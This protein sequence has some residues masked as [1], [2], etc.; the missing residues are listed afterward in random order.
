MRG[1]MFH[2]DRIMGRVVCGNLESRDGGEIGEHALFLT[3][4]Q[5]FFAKANTLDNRP[6]N[7]IQSKRLCTLERIVYY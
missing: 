7:T 2:S 6:K 1:V 5:Y 3:F 4:I